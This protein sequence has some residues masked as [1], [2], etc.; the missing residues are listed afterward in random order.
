MNK[1]AL[2]RKHIRR[3]INKIR[4]NEEQKT[5]NKKTKTKQITTKTQE[6][7]SLGREWRYRWVERAIRTRKKEYSTQL[8]V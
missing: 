3:N 5:N 2:W 6:E 8:N 7:K 4:N 1:N